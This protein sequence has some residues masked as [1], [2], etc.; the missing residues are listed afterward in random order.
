MNKK[1]K[2]WQITIGEPIRQDGDDIRLHR[3]GQMCE[4]LAQ[5]GHDIT[6]I[7]SSFFHQKR[8]QRTDRTQTY[9]ITDSYRVVCLKARSYMK[10]IS[11]NRFASHRDASKSFKQWLRSNPEKP[12]LIFASYPIEELCREAAIYAE[13]NNIPIIMDCRDFWPDI[14]VDILPRHLKPLAKFIFLP[15]ELK[16][17]NTLSMA[18]AISGHTGSAMKWGVNKAQRNQTELDFFFPFSYPD[19]KLPT[20]IP[21]GQIKILFL[22]TIS[23]RSGLE[24]YIQAFGALPP[25]LKNKVELHIAGTGDHEDALK[26]LSLKC[27]AN[28]HFHG[29]LDKQQMQNHM[30]S[31]DFGL[32]PYDRQDF[33][34]S[35]PNKFIEYLSAGLPIFTCTVGEVKTFIEQHKCGL[36]STTDVASIKNKLIEIIDSG[37]Q[38]KVSDIHKIFINNFSQDIVYSNVEDQI[39]KI[40]KKGKISQIIDQELERFRYNKSSK[41]KLI[42]NI[43]SYKKLQSFSEQINAD[44]AEPYKFY[45][46]K[47]MQYISKNQRVLE[48]GAG[49]GENSFVCLEQ[50][51]HLTALDIAEYSLEAFREKY[52]ACYGNFIDTYH[53]DFINMNV[54]NQHFDHVISA[55]SISYF[56]QDD[57]VKKLKMI[58]QPNGLFIAVDSWNCNPVFRLN[59]WIQYLKRDRTKITLENMPDK[60]LIKKLQ[61]HF[62][63]ETKHFGCLLF[64]RPILT[65]AL[66]EKQIADFISVTDKW[67][68]TRLLGFKVV[69]IARRKENT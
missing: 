36:Y 33:H 16:A 47:L 31:S 44:L 15:F 27:E 63:V 56:A 6:F 18:D 3:A 4:W 53:G 41:E 50:G 66:S 20:H 17:Q 68:P 69:I 61:H 5:K 34:I 13:V 35:L 38:R 26:A 65:L 64:L 7:N 57:F 10:S 12:D 48:V 59:R 24:K 42:D 40:I 43:S 49:S 55:G 11:W 19:T 23:K 60:T 37:H 8:T 14:F 25:S 58:I 45:E 29:W 67:L 51:A 32:L 30:I 39:F 9:K 22:G 54:E 1:L 62:D 46:N 2:I 21:T 28:V 52:T